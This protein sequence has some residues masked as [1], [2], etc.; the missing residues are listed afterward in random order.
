MQPAIDAVK[1]SR[2]SK[3]GGRL[4]E[5]VIAAELSAARQRVVLA[6]TEL[7]IALDAIASPLRARC[8]DSTAALAR[9]CVR[10]W[11]DP[12]PQGVTALL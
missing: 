3:E 11:T 6:C 12:S 5:P 10:R 8:V 4:L 1:R 7:P 2:A 9:A